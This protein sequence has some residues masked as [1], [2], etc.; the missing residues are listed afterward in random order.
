MLELDDGFRGGVCRC[1]Q[2]GAL[3]RVPMTD[4]REVQKSRPAEPA[5]PKNKP[6]SVSGSTADPS[7]SHT[8]LSHSDRP[9]TPDIPSS[10]RPVRPESTGAF[11]G[12]GALRPSRPESPL[13]ERLAQRP[14]APPPPDTGI[15]SGIRRSQSPAP[16]QQRGKV[17]PRSDSRDHGRHATAGSRKLANLPIWVYAVAAAVVL[18]IVIVVLI[19]AIFTITKPSSAPSA[20]HQAR[21]KAPPVSTVD[22]LGIPIKSGKV[23]FSLDGS[24][25][26]IGSFNVLVS[27]LKQSINRLSSASQVRIA[28]WTPSG[29]KLYPSKGWLTATDKKRVFH[30]LLAYSP[31]G[32]TSMTKMIIR[33]LKIGAEQNIFATQKIIAPANL[34]TAVHPA[35]RRGQI[36]DVISIDGERR[37]LKKLAESTG[38]T[39]KMVSLSDLQ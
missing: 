35:I 5:A 6:A 7:A 38:G 3:L 39:F 26:N 21:P 25:A 32:S 14:A 10:H 15:S 30:S 13:T 17:Q 22:F 29:L 34:L 16:R 28:V 8:N 9:E 12:S 24:S 18:L 27:I 19:G 4:T 31:Y 33:T 1:S 2:C 36:I 23:I 11:A 37:E 20:A